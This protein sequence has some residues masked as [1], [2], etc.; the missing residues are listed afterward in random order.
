M[1]DVEERNF[2]QFG[3]KEEQKKEKE[4]E[5]EAFQH[6]ISGQ[7][8]S[9]SSLHFPKILNGLLKIQIIDTGIY[10]LND[11]RINRNWNCKG[12]H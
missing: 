10:F 12:K 2:S 7:G 4:E 11:K 1:T 9:S 5:K 3:R 8:S 6:Q